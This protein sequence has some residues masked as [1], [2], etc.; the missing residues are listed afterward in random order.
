MDPLL[1]TDELAAYAHVPRKTVIYWR[2]SG[3]GPKGIR[4]GKR[5]L[6]RVSAVEAWLAERERASA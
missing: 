3:Q 2:A 4:V 5:V 1:S 6:Y